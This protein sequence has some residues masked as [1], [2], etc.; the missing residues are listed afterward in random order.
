MIETP[1]NSSPVLKVLQIIQHLQSMLFY[2]IE[3]PNHLWTEDSTENPTCFRP[4]FNPTVDIFWGYELIIT[5]PLSWHILVFSS[6][7]EVHKE[8]HWL[9]SP[10][11]VE[12][13]FRAHNY[14]GLYQLHPPSAP[15]ISAS[16]IKMHVWKLGMIP[17]LFIGLILTALALV[18]FLFNVYIVLALILTKQVHFLLLMKLYRLNIIFSHKIH[19]R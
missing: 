3:I 13:A 6:T 5:F 14:I 7:G 17:D 12:W 16:D 8:N 2:T 10:R 18:G 11:D 9:T 4:V 1:F 15:H 19:K